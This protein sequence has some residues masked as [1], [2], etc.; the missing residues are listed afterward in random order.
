M[1]L[2]G[3]LQQHSSNLL[4]LLSF[5]SD[6]SFQKMMAQLSQCEFAIGKTQMVCDMNEQETENYEKT[7]KEIGKY[8]D[9]CDKHW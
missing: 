5:F 9:L 4:S 2:F 3:I 6:A 8:S 1:G 7:Y